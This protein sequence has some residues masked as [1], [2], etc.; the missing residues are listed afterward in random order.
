[1]NKIWVVGL[2]LCF[3][4][5]DDDGGGGSG[6]DSSKKVSDL[7]DKEFATIC[8]SIIGK[9]FSGITQQH[10]CTFGATLLSEDKAEC[11]EVRDT[12]VEDEEE[13]IGNVKDEALQ[14]CDETVAPADCDVTVAKLEKCAND[15]T[16]AFTAS[17]KKVSCDDIESA[18]EYEEPESCADVPV[19]CFPE[20]E[21]DEFAPSLTGLN[22]RARLA[23]RRAGH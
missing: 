1:M 19:E 13:T 21:S 17:L 4:C 15:D 3:A 11:L 16:A 12:C 14:G 8:K 6:V 2:A 23:K 18:G 20:D 10:W 7:T 5:G 9:Q 22:A